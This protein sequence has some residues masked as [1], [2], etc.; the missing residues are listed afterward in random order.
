MRHQICRLFL[1]SLC[2]FLY[3]LKRKCMGSHCLCFLH[4]A[5]SPP[6]SFLISFFQIHLT[7]RNLRDNLFSLCFM[8]AEER[9]PL[10]VLSETFDKWK[11]LIRVREHRWVSAFINAPIMRKVSIRAWV[12]IKNHRSIW[13]WFP[14]HVDETWA[15][16]VKGRKMKKK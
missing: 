1:F 2:F 14:S 13:N 5:A 12:R 8:R 11:S 3:F 9:N 10:G 7:S 16:H 4:S 6:S 15:C